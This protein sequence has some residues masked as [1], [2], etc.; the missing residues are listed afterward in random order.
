MRVR[1]L[2]SDW[3]NVCVQIANMLYLESP[4]GVGF[5]YSDDQK[6]VTNDK[7]VGE[8]SLV[9]IKSRGPILKCLKC[10]SSSGVTEQLLGSV[11][12]FPPVPR[13]QQE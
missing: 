13:V 7:E 8:S 6:Y 10:V 4:A 3:L 9:L 11:G 12:V 1:F 5:S 2:T